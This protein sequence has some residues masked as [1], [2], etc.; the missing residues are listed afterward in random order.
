MILHQEAPNNHTNMFLSFK[1]PLGDWLRGKE[2]KKGISWS[3]SRQALLGDADLL[4]CCNQ[5]GCKNHVIHLNITPCGV[6]EQTFCQT[7]KCM[8]SGSLKNCPYRTPKRGS[9]PKRRLRML[10]SHQFTWNRSM[11]VWTH[12]PF[13]ATPEPERQ[14][15]CEKGCKLLRAP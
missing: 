1:Y 13:K 3:L 14:L 10:P 8:L 12:F 4:A 5:Q 7:P 11:L 2:R 15:P 6:M 9:L